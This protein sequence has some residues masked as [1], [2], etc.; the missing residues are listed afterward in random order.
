MTPRATDWG[1][2]ALVS[3]G[4]ATGGLTLY[5]GDSGD[6]WVFTVH[7]AGG[8]ALVGLVAWKLRRVWPRLRHAQLRDRFSRIG[9][10]SLVVVC[11]AL[12][13]GI[14]WS[15]GLTPDPLGFSLLAWHGALGAALIVI[16]AW[17]AATRVRLPAHANPSG[18]RDVLRAGAL[19]AAAYGAW[20]LQPAAAG[21]VGLRSAK[22][23]FTGSYEAGSFSGNGFPSTSWVAD[24]PRE[25]HPDR[26]AL[27]IAGL[28]E[29]PAELRLRDLVARDELT[30]TLDCTGGFYSTQEWA[31][32]RLD[33]L[34][35][36][37]SP[38]P[39]AR[40]LRVVS[41]TG[42]RW[43]FA[44][45]EAGDL[46]LA[47]H[48]GDEPLSH[49]HGA[50]ARL[51]APGRRGF[52]WVKWVERLELVHEPDPGAVAST[53]WSSFTASGRGAA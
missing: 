9:I 36:M 8:F 28:V 22:R 40:H 46:L 48:V 20:R 1:L 52:E 43:S 39:G 27:Q 37:V 18:R 13:S 10:A 7:G 12:A 32:M 16:V 3:I 5:A 11:A 47:T 15:S 25:L 45:R 50:P 38:L 24:N 42:Y 44:L 29:N 2:A 21:L 35:A 17:H 6:R 31:G 49:E 34:L 4:L 14:A 30:A 33:R 26:W 23:R 41:R 19:G 53:V 51:V